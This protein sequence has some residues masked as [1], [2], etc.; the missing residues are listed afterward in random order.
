MVF[1]LVENIVC[2]QYESL[3]STIN[4]HL[5]FW[6]EGTI[7]IKH[8]IVQLSIDFLHVCITYHHNQTNL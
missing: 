3:T 2:S 1:V 4:I 8:A 6:A 5:I 7:E